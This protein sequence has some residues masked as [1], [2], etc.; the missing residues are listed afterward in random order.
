M[1]SGNFTEQTQTTMGATYRNVVEL[2]TPIFVL[3]Q[4]RR[5]RR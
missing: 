2:V 4:R 5:C 1:V 3:D